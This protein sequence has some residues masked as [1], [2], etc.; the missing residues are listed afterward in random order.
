MPIKNKTQKELIATLIMIVSTAFIVFNN[1][2]QS[3]ILLQIPLSKIAM[4]WIAGTCLMVGIV[5][6]SY[7]NRIL[8]I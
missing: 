3:F 7:L 8:K 1:V 4:Y 5:W 6:E 2:G